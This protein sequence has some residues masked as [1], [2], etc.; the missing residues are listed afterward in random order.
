MRG[1][2]GTSEDEDDRMPLEPA[3]TEFSQWVPWRADRCKI[4]S[5]WAELLAV[6][7]DGDHK[8]L[9]REMWASFQLLQQMRELGM[10][11]A[12][13]QAPPVSPCFHWQKFMPPGQSIYTC[14]D[15]REIPQEKVVA[16]ARALQHWVEKIDLPAGGR[17]CLLAESVKELREK[18]KCYLSFSN[19]E[20]F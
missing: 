17:P 5:W 4:P 16:Y 18:V 15:I 3:V 7:E 20:G 19:E 11:E 10:K 9:A 2:L 6:P 14:R 12:S 1:S 8:R 13:L